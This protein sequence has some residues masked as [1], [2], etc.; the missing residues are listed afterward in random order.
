MIRFSSILCEFSPFLSA[1]PLLHIFFPTDASG[2]YPRPGGGVYIFQDISSSISKR[3][4]KRVERVPSTCLVPQLEAFPHPG[5]VRDEPDIE[6]VGRGVADRRQGGAAQVTVL[7]A[8][9]Q[10]NGNTQGWDKTVSVEKVERRGVRGGDRFSLEVSLKVGSPAQTT[11]QSSPN[12]RRS[13]TFILCKCVK[14][15]P[16]DD[17]RLLS[18]GLFLWKSLNNIR[19]TRASIHILFC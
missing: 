11:Q 4:L 5:S 17:L 16:S 10:H 9:L 18:L 3:R 6:D 2:W 19:L 7:T 8:P 12:W 14:I 15:S 1:S 13:W